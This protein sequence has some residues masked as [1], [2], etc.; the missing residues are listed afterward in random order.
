MK[1]C[2]FQWKHFHSLQPMLNCTSTVSQSFKCTIFVIH[3]S[4]Q[5][6]EKGI[7]HQKMG[8]EEREEEQKLLTWPPASPPPPH[9]MTF[10]IV[11]CLTSRAPMLA[12][13]NLN[14]AW[15]WSNNS[16]RENYSENYPHDPSAPVLLRAFIISFKG[17]WR[18]CR[19]HFHPYAKHSIVLMSESI[20]G[21]AFIQIFGSP[22]C[23][24]HP[25]IKD[26]WNS[27]HLGFSLFHRRKWDLR[28]PEVPK[29]TLRLQE[30]LE[31]AYLPITDKERNENW[32]LITV[33][34]PHQRHKIEGRES[35]SSERQN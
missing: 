20:Q 30:E 31:V 17:L 1:P 4:A 32:V 29:V 13:I 25:Q 5:N 3:W 11:V 28:G 18:W 6:L 23:A 15:K 9:P 21:P 2:Y 24:R 19:S 14:Y 7:K 8:A 33:S 35:K 22:L 27:D 34:F 12:P 26:F 10:A 16:Q